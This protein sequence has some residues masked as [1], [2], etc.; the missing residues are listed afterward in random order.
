MS[1][2]IARASGSFLPTDYSLTKQGLDKLSEMD[3]QGGVMFSAAVRL[4]GPVAVAAAQVLTV[5]Y[6]A[7]GVLVKTAFILPRAAIYGLSC[8]KFDPLSFA[9]PS[10]VVNHAARA[11]VGLPLVFIAP[12][13]TLV[14]PDWAIKVINS[15]G[16]GQSEVEK[17]FLS[18]CKEIFKKLI[19]FTIPPPYDLE[20]PPKSVRITAAVA[21]AIAI[22]DY[23][24]AWYREAEKTITSQGAELAYK[25]ASD[26]GCWVR[27]FTSYGC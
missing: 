15:V 1:L 22:A 8:G 14:S 26:L 24:Q 18:R 16:A 27:N 17:G 7:V 4:A 23:G 2:Q 10:D 11:I 6:H 25:S 20:V 19:E 3:A 21:A 12:A 9:S 13:A 5:V